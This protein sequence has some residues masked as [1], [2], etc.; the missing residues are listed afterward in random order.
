[1][2]SE[3]PPSYLPYEPTEKRWDIWQ[4]VCE[5]DLD[6]DLLTDEEGYKTECLNYYLSIVKDE[7]EFGYGAGCW[8]HRPGFC[9]G[10]DFAFEN[11]N[12]ENT[13]MNH[14]EAS[15]TNK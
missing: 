1:M 9:P 5:D 13:R 2:Q 7:S 6:C 15:C 4:K 8:A 10:P 14:W 11:L 3:P 12:Y